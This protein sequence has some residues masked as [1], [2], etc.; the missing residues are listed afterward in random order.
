MFSVSR[1]ITKSSM[2]GSIFKLGPNAF[3]PEK[4]CQN[5]NCK[6]KNPKNK[7]QTRT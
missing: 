6:F 3:E 5:Q 4:S 1:L 7:A 2:G